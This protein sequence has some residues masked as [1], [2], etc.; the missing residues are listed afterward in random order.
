MLVTEAYVSEIQSF[1]QLKSFKFHS[2]TALII[3]MLLT[4]VLS[5]ILKHKCDWVCKNQPS[6][7]IKI[8]LFFQLQTS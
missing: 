7:C 8:A 2:S 6:G 5:S 1:V 3:I 4:L